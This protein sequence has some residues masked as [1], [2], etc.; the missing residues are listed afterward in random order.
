MPDWLIRPSHNAMTIVMTIGLG[1]MQLVLRCMAWCA[2][3]S[4]FFPL[5]SATAQEEAKG[6]R[7]MLDIPI[8]NAED[9]VKFLARMHQRSVLFQTEDVVA[10]NTNPLKGRYSLEQALD[11]MFEGTPLQGGLTESGVIT[12]SLRNIETPEGGNKPM[13]RSGFFLTTILSSLGVTAATAQ[14]IAPANQDRDLIVVTGSRIKG[15]SDAGTIAVTTID[16][17]Q[18]D[19]F[20]QTSVGELL[21]NLPQAGSFEIN[22][23]A[24]GPNSARG[25]VA[26]VNLRGLGSGNTLILLNDR[27]ITQHAVFQD[28]STQGAGSV[29]RVITNVQAFPAAGI[30]RVEILRDG[31]SALYGSDAV[32]GV[33]NT[34]LVPDFEGARVTARYSGI[35]DTDE[36]EFK[37]NLTTGLEFNDGASKLLFTGSFFTR[38]GLFATELGPQ[39]SNVDKR[40]FLE[41]QGSPY[42][43]SS[44]FRNTSTRSPFGQFRVGELL[45]SG[46]FNPI[47][48]GGLTASD[49]DFHVQPCGFSGTREVLGTF[50]PLVGCVGLDDGNL[51][52]TLRF[53]FN[54]FQ[55]VDSFGE[56]QEISLDPISQLGRQLISDA[57]RYNAY[58]LFE[59]DFGN[60][61]EFFGEALFY[62][63]STDS[64][65]ATNPIDDGLAFVIV[66][67]TNFYNPVGAITSPNR[68][69]GISAPDEGLDV[70][71]SR[72]RPTE[73]GPRIFSVDSTTYRLV[74]GLR[75]NINNWDWES[76]FQYS[77]SDVEDTSQNRISKT[78]LQAELAK[79]TPDAINP[80]GGPNAN[81]QEQ[82]D[83]IRVT[84]TNKGETSLT[85][86]DFRASNSELFTGWAGAIGAAFGAEWRRESYE[87]DRDPRLDGTIQFA[88]GNGGVSDVS[89]IAGISPTEDSQA[90]R[91]VLATFGE[92]LV[93]L[94]R[95]NHSVFINEL[96]FQVAGRIQ[97]FTDIEEFV[98]K[99]KVSLSYFPVEWINFRAAYSQGFRAPN[100]VQLNRG[101]IS[102]L[103]QGIV[104]FARATVTGDPEDTGDTFRPTVRVSNPDL[105]PERSRTFVAGVTL[106]IPFMED[107]SFSADYWNLRQNDIIGT[108][109]P[110]TILALDA[111]AIQQ[112]GS[113]PRVA[114][115]PITVADQALF[116]AF[117]AANPGNQRVAVGSVQF[118]NDQ[119]INQDSQNTSGIDIAMRGSFEFNELGRLSFFA[120][121]TRL[122]KFD[123]NRVEGVDAALADPQFGA[124]FADE[125]SALVVDRRRLNGNPMWRSSANVT[126]R[127]GPVGIGTSVRYVS[128]VLDT[129][130]DNVDVDGDGKIDFFP[131]D[132][133]TRVNSYIDYRFDVGPVEPVRIRFGVNNVFDAEPPL[134][135]ESRGY[136]TS[137]HSVRGREFYIQLRGSL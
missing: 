44:D 134:A 124:E 132:S 65:R 99:P 128:G 64:Q 12:V 98:G 56:G 121:A 53:D 136:F 20:G 70:L 48:V 107:L 89:D 42:A 130:V 40:A 95:S 19:T 131:V 6:A 62:H 51:N 133:W 97:Y 76:A 78:L 127:N 82:M 37:I 47:D 57:N 8:Q 81:T 75:G 55:P 11:Q 92:V 41:A 114:R 43:G 103:S 3:F 26:T 115:F 91:S 5:T 59:H 10:V 123:L 32:G 96:N 45:P 46:E 86:W 94:A 109:G 104:D 69:A 66:P 126:Y 102:R 112:G 7:L 106:D 31:A 13:K 61:L 113:D 77:A 4:G 29:P 68:V 38:D 14:D 83:R 88:A 85:S 110:E 135:D 93:P 22:D 137:L 117:N 90:S 84:V 9:A 16:K 122:L 30:D 116:D 50:D 33:V 18:L 52:S 60:G 108:L 73:L 100:L 35:A 72:W 79:D 71:I 87:E 67:R 49:G 120:E 21:E 101:D 15:A 58:S 28:V 125:F 129:S 119:Y 27:R 105:K 74:G 39:F 1:R 17:E 2:I 34:I 118:V 24:D 63:S 54:S 25:D 23:S 36:R 80:F 111:L